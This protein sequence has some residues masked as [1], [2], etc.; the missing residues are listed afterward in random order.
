MGHDPYEHR[1]D[2]DDR[3]RWERERSHRGPDSRG[4]DSRGRDPRSHGGRDERGFFERAGEEISSWFGGD[5]DDRGS[6]GDYRQSRDREERGEWMAHG[7]GHGAGRGPE[8]GRRDH[9]DG[10]FS[11]WGSSRSDRERED[12]PRGHRPTSWSSSERDYGGPQWRD[13]AFGSRGRDDERS[14]YRP[15]A[16]DYGRSGSPRGEYRGRDDDGGQRDQSKWDRDEYRRTSFA[17]SREQSNYDDLHYNECRQRHMDEFDREYDEYRRERNSKFESDFG[18]W[19]ERRQSKREMLRQIRENMDVVGSDGKPLGTVERVA[20]DRIILTP[21][22]PDAG[23]SP[24]SLSCTDID[25]VEGNRLILESSAEKAQERW[26]DDS[27]GRALFE[28]EDQGSSGPHVLGRS[29]SG[30]YR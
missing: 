12:E 8:H 22:D 29:F 25:R 24:H 7:R 1:G 18:G 3:S 4:P 13:R 28:R 19:R 6:R 20:G 26:R 27:R 15:M 14:G 10:W 23:G 5:D 17:G 21:S 30:T 16:G 9:D 11:G 2:R